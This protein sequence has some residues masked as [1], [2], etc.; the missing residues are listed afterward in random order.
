MQ[1]VLQPVTTPAWVLFL[2]LPEIARPNQA[3][4][5]AKAPVLLWAL[6]LQSRLMPLAVRVPPALTSLLRLEIRRGSVQV[7]L[8]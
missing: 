1:R 7:T 2:R 6:R 3:A 8:L 4:V 5:S